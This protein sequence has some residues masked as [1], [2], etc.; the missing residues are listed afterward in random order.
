M[1]YKV[2]FDAEE[3]MIIAR[4]QGPLKLAELIQLVIDF[5]ILAKQVNCSY[6]LTILNE[7]ELKIS[8]FE[9]Y[10]FPQLV[11]DI[12]KAHGLQTYNFKRAFVGTVEQKSLKFYETVSQNRGNYTHL[13]YDIEEAKQWLRKDQVEHKRREV[14]S[15]G[16]KISRI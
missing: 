12:F 15:L 16:E 8:M 1:T 13:F 11:T 6:I 5:V 10:T 7:A 14:K 2:E 4:A 3:N 9:F